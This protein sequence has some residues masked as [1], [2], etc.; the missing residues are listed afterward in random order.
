MAS[1]GVCGERPNA[2]GHA[3]TERMMTR[4]ALRALASMTRSTRVVG[5]RGRGRGGGRAHQDF[6]APCTFD[7]ASIRKLAL[8]TTRS[9][10]RRPAVTW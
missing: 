9:P 4:N 1:S 8:V 5:A 3:K 6:S 10:A 7:S 2:A